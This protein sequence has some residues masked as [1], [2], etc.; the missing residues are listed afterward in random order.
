M[1]IE[2]N[3]RYKVEE[4]DKDYCILSYGDEKRNTINV[5]NELIPFWANSGENLYYKNGKFN[6]DV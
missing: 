5:P 2:P 6:R 3:T 4:R 1:K